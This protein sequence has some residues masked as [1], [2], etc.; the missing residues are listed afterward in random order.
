MKF[1]N[2]FREHRSKCLARDVFL[3]L[4]AY[5]NLLAPNCARL[6]HFAQIRPQT[7]HG[8]GESQRLHEQGEVDDVKGLVSLALFRRRL[9]GLAR[10]I[11]IRERLLLFV[12]TRTFHVLS[13]FSHRECSTEQ[14]IDSTDRF[15][16]ANRNIT[17]TLLSLG[18]LNSIEYYSIKSSSG[19][20]D[21][22]HTRDSRDDDVKRPGM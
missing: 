14:L 16:L 11:S 13:F 10:S 22:N 18:R 4:R 17:V 9:E 19:D 7:G 6:T 5:G 15:L 21:N 20:H 12:F 1:L 2:T 3:F 8:D